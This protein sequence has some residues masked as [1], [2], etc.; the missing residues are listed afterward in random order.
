[1]EQIRYGQFFRA[2]AGHRH[3]TLAIARALWRARRTGLMWRLV[4]QF[5]Q[6]AAYTIAFSLLGVENMVGMPYLAWMLCGIAPWFFFRAAM[7]YASSSLYECAALWK[8]GACPPGILPF[9]GV[10]SA[11]PTYLLWS[12]IA[13]GAAAVYGLLTS[14]AWFL[15]YYMACSVLN[16]TA[17][18]YLS[19]AFAPFNPDFRRGLEWMLFLTFWTTPIVWPS[20]L[21]SDLMRMFSRL[22]PLYY[23]IEG[24]RN[25]LL[26]G[27]GPAWNDTLWFFML[28]LC[29]FGIGGICFVR[30]KKHYRE[31]MGDAS[32]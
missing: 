7:E 25:C 32:V 6:A 28:T 16:A 15:P 18:G 17:Q 21:L 4:P 2:F 11:L 24:T 3:H 29:L 1:M 20:A 13:V 12:G 14:G 9:A 5:A 22:N 31:V 8:S 23:I 30:L 19:A 26:Y 27:A 10:L